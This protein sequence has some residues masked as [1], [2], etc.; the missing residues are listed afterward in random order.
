MREVLQHYSVA[1][2]RG[3]G[4]K[5]ENMMGLP[6]HE[7]KF[8]IDDPIDRS[9]QHTCG[10]VLRPKLCVGGCVDNGTHDVEFHRGP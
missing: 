1:R 3:K 8:M 10:D 9:Q 4:N 2:G 7:G 6:L 5:I